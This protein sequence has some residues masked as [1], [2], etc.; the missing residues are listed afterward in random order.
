M[1]DLRSGLLSATVSLNLMNVVAEL[2]ERAILFLVDEER[3]IPVGSFGAGISNDKLT[4]L[5]QGVRLS[6]REPSVFAECAEG[7]RPRFGSYGADCL[8]VA[9]LSAV[10]PPRSGIFAVL[11][12][13]GSTQVI[14]LIYID[15][16]ATS[17]A[18]R[19]SRCWI[20][21]VAPGP[22]PGERLLRGRARL[23]T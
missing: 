1:G 6:L 23:P 5:A 3:L 21:G 20:C 15:N 18:W 13:S 17:A 8:P 12:V 16:G 22:R 9:F 10:T 11:P 14:A 19:T 7:D 4:R 2:I